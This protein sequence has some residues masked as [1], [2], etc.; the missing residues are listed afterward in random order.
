M[1]V[2]YRGFEI[3]VERDKCLA[4]YEL[5]YYYIMRLSD[6]W[7]LEDSFSDTADSVRDMIKYLKQHVDSH[8]S[9]EKDS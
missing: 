8:L 4:G 6:Y 2:K 9:Q 3:M 5:L 1:K 7:I